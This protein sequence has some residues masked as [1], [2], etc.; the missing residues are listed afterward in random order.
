MM[1]MDTNVMAPRSLSTRWALPLLYAVSGLC[2]LVYQLVW[3]RRLGLVFGS[4]FTAVSVV[5]AVFFA[6]LALGGWGGGRLAR[7]VAHP[8]RTY[9]LLEAGVTAAALLVPSML[10]MAEYLY[11][12]WYPSVSASLRQ[13]ALVR[14]GLAA[15][16]LLLPTTLM[17]ATV[18]LI[19]RCYSTRDGRNGGDTGVIY[20]LNSLGAALGVLAAGW[21]FFRWMGVNGANSLAISLNALVALAAL[22]LAR[23]E[24]ES[25]PSTD[26]DGASVFEGEAEAVRPGLVLA[27]F[28]LSG[29]L[30]VGYELLWMRTF[31]LFFRDSIYLYVSCLAAVIAGVAVGSFA[32]GRLADRVR[33]RRMFL[34]WLFGASALLHTAFLLGVV[35]LH[36]PLSL[37]AFPYPALETV[38]IFCALVPVFAVAGG[39]FPV[40]ARLLARRA[41]DTGGGAGRAYAVNTLGSI[42]GA[43]LTPFCLLPALGLD[44]TMW[45]FLVCGL[46]SAAAL[47]RG[48][49]TR[50][51]LLRYAATCVLLSSLLFIGAQRQGGVF[52]GI[53][54]QVKGA[55]RLLEARQGALGGNWVLESPERGGQIVLYENLVAFSRGGSPSF[56]VQGFIPLILAD[57][58]PRN[59]LGLCFGGGLTYHAARY[60]PEIRSL[61]LVDISAG[62]VGM[63][64]RHL[65]INESL[66]RDSRVRFFIDD[67]YSYVKYAQK[68]YDLILID[69]NPPFYSHNCATLY[70][71]EFYR[72]CARRLTHRGLFTQVLPIKQM[73]LAEAQS[74]M[75]TFASV[76]PHT[77]LWWN[78][79]DPLMIGS[80]EPIVLEPDGMEARLNRPGLGDALRRYSGEA[81]FD[82]LGHFLSGLLLADDGFRRAAG[83]GPMNS[84]DKNCLEYSRE[85]NADQTVA[86]WLTERLEP[87]EAMKS[88]FTRPDMI[89]EYAPQLERRRAYLMGLIRREM[90]LARIRL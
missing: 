46:G 16:L 49:A 7:R 18:P 20:A 80:N 67:A 61:D 4:S 10:D 57:E 2:S 17:G 78:E 40:V 6:G 23:R 34:G 44:G 13:T 43:L 28:G 71:R 58:V 53:L 45:L 31:L 69:S 73:T 59:V 36:R 66:K 79:L 70:S 50:P 41:S 85:L 29:F 88:L 21:I 90:M 42:A 27:C 56:V 35:R 9:G 33:S 47:W 39:T 3:M 12:A 30:Y 68:S 5:T 11:A 76:F 25:R 54:N 62:N 86:P 52:L 14:M 63:A 8:L 65:A 82:T 55:S 1:V 19:V 77:L 24:A 15:C 84:V 38:F 48:G 83:T 64:L 74:V 51:V 87:W 75:R 22:L 37:L 89:E 72:Q 26:G 32:A 60:F 81:K